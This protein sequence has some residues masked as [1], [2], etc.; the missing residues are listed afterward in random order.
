MVRGGPNSLPGGE[1]VTF[2]GVLS[3]N[4]LFWPDILKNPKKGCFREGCKRGSKGVQ[5]GPKRHFLG[6]VPGRG[7]PWWG[8]PKWSLLE[9]SQ[10]QGGPKMVPPGEKSLPEI[11]KYLRP[12][13]LIFYAF[14]SPLFWGGPKVAFFRKP[15]PWGTKLVLGGSKKGSKKGQKVVFCP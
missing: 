7:L 15:R 8:V 9:D 4:L 2:L 5:N 11:P 10:I 6:R 14:F 13:A 1:K 3:G 12:Q